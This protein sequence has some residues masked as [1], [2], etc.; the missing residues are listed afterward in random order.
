MAFPHLRGTSFV[1]ENGGCSSATLAEVSAE[2]DELTDAPLISV[3]LP[4]V[5]PWPAVSSAM[6]SLLSQ[7]AA[8]PFEV[9]V[10]DGHGA[11]LSATCPEPAV[12]W[13][14]L[15]GKD[16]FALRA[17]G[18]A[19]ARGAIVVVSEDHCTA[20]SDWLASIA[21]AHHADARS[22]LVGVTVNHP[23]SRSSAMDRANFVLTFA[24]QNPSRLDIR[25]DRLPVPTN[26]SFKRAALP[27]ASLG[28]GEFE[29]AWLAQLREAR[30]LGVCPSVVLQH[31][32]S[33]GWRVL[34]VH[35][36][37]GRAYGATVRGW[38]WKERWRW[39]L[40]LPLLPLR[41]ARLSIPDLLG[42][43]AGS[44][45]HFGDLF[46]LVTLILA[47]LTGQ[48]LGATSGAGTSRQRL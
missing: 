10:L 42:E 27:P 23:D 28:A 41:L 24:G 9:L 31:K 30:A 14:R 7:T 39:W 16:S 17:A 43:A 38:P 47:N 20:P 32:Q 13:L 1:A 44:T 5:N 15:P 6:A 46:C 3:L 19:A 37:S 29:Y 4:T 8:P 45:P 48:I 12:R 36:A 21:A 35:L 2:I 18:I 33:W 26:L 40:A 25:W 34:G 22:A 11:A